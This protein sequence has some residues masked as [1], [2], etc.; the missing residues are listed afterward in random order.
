MKWMGKK[1]KKAK[2]F[3][4]KRKSLFSFSEQTE[5]SRFTDLF[6]FLF[7]SNGNFALIWFTF[8][9]YCDAE[10]SKKSA[11]G[12]WEIL[13]RCL[14]MYFC[15]GEKN[16]KITSSVWIQIV[17]Q[18]RMT[19]GHPQLQMLNISFDGLMSLTKRP[20]TDQHSQI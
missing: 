10:N 14:C 15:V 1:K 13:S 5:I 12:D 16:W 19:G 8:C 3:I 20:A 17:E 6:V 2:N 7:W 9:F 11:K 4:N 18:R